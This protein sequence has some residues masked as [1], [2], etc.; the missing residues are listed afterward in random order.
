M[1][2]VA[3][4]VFRILARRCRSVDQPKILHAAFQFYHRVEPT[5]QVPTA[6][7][8]TKHVT[9]RNKCLVAAL[10]HHA[11]AGVRN[12]ERVVTSAKASRL[13][14][15]KRQAGVYSTDLAALNSSH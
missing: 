8:V 10:L 12:H 1:P 11:R 4:I 9:G 13:S 15:S 7:A 6:D 5:A 3:R 2:A 14:T